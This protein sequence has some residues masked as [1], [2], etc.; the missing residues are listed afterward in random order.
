[1]LMS[2]VYALDNRTGREKIIKDDKHGIEEDNKIPD[3]L[4]LAPFKTSQ[5][6]IE[7]RA[8]ESCQDEPEIRGLRRG[9]PK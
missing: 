5:A 8:E 9:K 3:A 7:D 2:K 6:I 1:M 4:C